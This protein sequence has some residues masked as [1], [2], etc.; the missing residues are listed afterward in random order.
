MSKFLVR[1]EF[2][3]EAE[4]AVV[5]ERLLESEADSSSGNEEGIHDSNRLHV[6]IS[7]RYLW[8]TAINLTALVSTAVL[9]LMMFH[10]NCL[11]SSCAHRTTYYSLYDAFIIC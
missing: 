11:P 7:Q 10:H 2:G 1:Q 4:D 3:G 6:K 8:L 5:K 9:F